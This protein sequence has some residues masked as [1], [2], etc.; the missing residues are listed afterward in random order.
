MKYLLWRLTQRCTSCGQKLKSKQTMIERLKEINNKGNRLAKQLEHMPQVQ[1][2]KK[3][4]R[5][6]FEGEPGFVQS[7]LLIDIDLGTY[8]RRV[9]TVQHRLQPRRSA[10][11]TASADR[12]TGHRSSQKV[13][14]TSTASRV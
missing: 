4:H 11:T 12:Q 8:P 9:Q 7:L 5:I 13:S 2:C 6:I 10:L 14:P 1:S 3:C